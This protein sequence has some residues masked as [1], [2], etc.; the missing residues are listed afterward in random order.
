M[1]LLYSQQCSGS[2]VMWLANLSL[3]I[4]A[5]TVA[6]RINVSRNGHAL[7][8]LVHNILTAVMTNIVVNKSTHHAKP[9]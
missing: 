9:L 2:V 6:A 5:Q 8:S 7:T 1:N 4:R 3:S